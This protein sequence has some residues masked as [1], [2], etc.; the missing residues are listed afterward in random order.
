[1][2]PHPQ[3]MRT[4]TKW[5]KLL[6]RRPSSRRRASGS[7]VSS[8]ECKEFAIFVGPVLCAGMRWHR[9][10]I[11]RAVNGHARSC[12][13]RQH[14]SNNCKSHVSWGG[15]RGSMMQNVHMCPDDARRTCA[16]TMDQ[17]PTTTASH[18]TEISVSSDSPTGSRGRWIFC[19]GLVRTCSSWIKPFTWQYPPEQLAIASQSSRL[20]GAG[21]RQ[22]FS[23]TSC[24]TLTRL[25]SLRWQPG[26][27]D[28][29]GP[30][31]QRALKQ[32]AARNHG[33]HH[34]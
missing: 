5:P 30:K 6:Q 12:C 20:E 15:N 17:K 26:R 16:A 2:I 19:F 3:A 21:L 23:M 4:S 32:E 1:M 13:V 34:H 14:R 27:R 8:A 28:V 24:P 25:C 11:V 7:E 33:R 29:A 31:G 10:E 9:G 18:R 22:R